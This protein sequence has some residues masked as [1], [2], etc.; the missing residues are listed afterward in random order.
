MKSLSVGA[1]S[2]ICLLQSHDMVD[3]RRWQS[4]F[5]DDGQDGIVV[6]SIL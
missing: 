4:V 5:G 2:E 1:E 3:C 6:I